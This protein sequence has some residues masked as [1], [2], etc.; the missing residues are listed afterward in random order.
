MLLRTFGS[1]ARRRP[2]LLQSQRNLALPPSASEGK[3]KFEDPNP[4]DF[5][6][7]W[8]YSASKLVSYCLIPGVGFYFVL[9]QDYGDHE[10]VFQPIRR[11]VA[12]Q[13]ANFMT[14]S[15]EEEKFI[16]AQKQED[17]SS[18]S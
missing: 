1:I 11:W 6:P 9:I 8:V 13:K 12:R 2:T 17:K 15:P 16:K 10:H 3:S 7:P 4:S 5:R 18:N 14:L